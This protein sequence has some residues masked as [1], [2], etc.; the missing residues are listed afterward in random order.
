MTILGYARVS[1]EG[2]HL[3]GQLEALKAAGAEKIFQEKISGA[4]AN[5]PQLAKL[6]AALKAD[7]V[8]L[9]TK[10][11]RLGRSTRELLDLIE[12]IGKA[13]AAFRSLG[14]PLFDTTSSQGRLVSTLLAAIAEFERD[15]IRE[16][17]GEGR[18]RAMAAGKKF[19]RKPK[20]SDYQR[21]EAV[22]RRAAGESLASIAKSYAVDISMI[23]RLAPGYR[24]PFEAA[25]ADA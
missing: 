8:V 3:T 19:G 24:A 2:Q 5:R 22:K 11:D 12:R 14:D 25:D 6:M 4:R 1:T 9:V 21:E 18:K 15:L 13:G 10:L 20:L 7:D 17:T 16:R 23:S